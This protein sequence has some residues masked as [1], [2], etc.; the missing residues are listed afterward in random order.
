MLGPS[1]Y[2]FGLGDTVQSIFFSPSR[3]TESG[4]I[5]GVGPVFLIPSATDDYLGSGKWGAGP[6]AVVLTKKG[7]WTIGALGNYIWSF[8]GK[9]DRADVNA[10]FLQPLHILHHAART[11]A[12][13]TEATY[14][15]EGDIWSVPINAT[16]SKLVM[17]DKQPISR[18]TG[19]RC[20]AA[21]SDDGPDGLASR[22]GVTFLFP[23]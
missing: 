1:G 4:I 7:P 9:S 10:T 21:A 5:W 8:A 19:E 14:D 22:L 18:M 23:K 17:V 12:L 16:I 3:P 15:W 11:F 20:W 13:N 2:Q 6:T